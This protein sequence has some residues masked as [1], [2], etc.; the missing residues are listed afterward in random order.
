MAVSTG[1]LVLMV[2]FPVSGALAPKFDPRVLVSVGF[3]LTTFGLWRMTRIDLDIS[4]GMAVSWRACIAIGLPF[5]FIP[6]NTLCYAG[7][8]QHKNNEISGMSA[9]SRN[10]GGSVGI[11][12]VTTMLARLSQRHLSVLTQHTVDGNAPY[13]RMRGA[14]AGAWAAHNGGGAG[15]PDAIHAAGAQIY[16]IALR[17]SRLLAYVDVIWFMI[18][19]TIILIPLPFIMK[20]PK[21]VAAVTAVH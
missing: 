18:A 8:P 14:L 15:G 2:L 10:L 20:R 1:A 5:L 12:I 19:V 3:I 21:K 4:F 13:D 6:I 17:Q 9:L 7:I 16:N 11:S